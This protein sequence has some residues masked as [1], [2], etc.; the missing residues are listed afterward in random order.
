MITASTR[1]AGVI[2]DP[3]RHSLSPAIHNAAFRELGLDWVYLAFPV[4]AGAAPEALAAMRTLGMAGLSVT[5]PHKA[6]VIPALDELSPTAVAVG[7]VNCVYRRGALLVGENTDGAGFLDALRFDEGFD[8]AG[9]RCVV[10]GAGGAARA[11]ILALAQAGAADIAVVN[12]TPARGI[13]AAKLAGARGRAGT[14]EDLLRA[15]V[16]VNATPVGMA[17]PYA[18]AMPVDEDFLRSDQ[19]VV[20]L[21]YRPARTPLL[22]AARQRGAVPV[23]GLGT[24]IHQAAHAFRLWTALDPPLEAMSA[25]ALGALG[26]DD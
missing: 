25:A 14:P 12:R 9:A 11:V 6:D 13:K 20:D 19:L 23:N 22:V 17:G 2:G 4:P 7:A 10:I 3:V 15:Q 16:V 8:P 24:L 18:A 5:M 26:G 21:V 1:L